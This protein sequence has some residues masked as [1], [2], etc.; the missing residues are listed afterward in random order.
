MHKEM[1]A[2]PGQF[3]Q[4]LA[5]A[6]LVGSKALE[7]PQRPGQQRLIDV[8]EQG[9]ERRWRV[10]PIVIDPPPKERIETIGDFGQR[11]L[12]AT[13]DAQFPDLRPHGLQCRRA[14]GRVEATEQRL[15]P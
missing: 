12:G 5:R 1:R 8:P 7:L 14:D 2:L 11:Q 10:S 15:V 9:S 4:E 3:L 13:S 6:D